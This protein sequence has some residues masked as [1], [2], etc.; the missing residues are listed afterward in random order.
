MSCFDSTKRRHPRHG[1][2]KHVRCQRMA[3]Q[4]DFETFT[5][6]ASDRST[7]KRTSC[8]NGLLKRLDFDK[9]HPLTEVGANA[10]QTLVRKRSRLDLTGDP[11]ETT[12]LKCHP[13]RA[14]HIHL[15]K[16]AKLSRHLCRSCL[17]WMS[18]RT[19]ELTIREP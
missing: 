19:A 18:T 5:P 3:R 11:D 16:P 9:T 4:S 13:V 7:D 12:N 15:S 6:D 17:T 2:F 10:D 14:L 8:R 1:A